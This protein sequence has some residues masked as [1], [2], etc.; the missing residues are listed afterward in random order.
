VSDWTFKEMLDRLPVSEG[1]LRS[2]VRTRQIPLYRVGR[3]ILFQPERI[4]AWKAQGGT[5]AHRRG[6]GSGMSLG[7][8][9]DERGRQGELGPGP[10]G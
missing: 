2:L 7:P 5:D 8:D 1:T 4:A 3:K 10:A 6:G 9:G